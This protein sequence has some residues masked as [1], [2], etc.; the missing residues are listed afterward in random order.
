MEHATMHPEIS[1]RTLGRLTATMTLLLIPVI[2][3]VNRGAQCGQDNAS[4]LRMGI[5]GVHLAWMADR[6][7]RTGDVRSILGA[8]RPNFRY[9]VSTG[10]DGTGLACKSSASALATRVMISA[11]L[12]A[13]WSCP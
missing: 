10:G 11:C 12:R 5:L 13:D 1:S 7:G 6:C 9:M 4:H 3:R 2:L 8:R